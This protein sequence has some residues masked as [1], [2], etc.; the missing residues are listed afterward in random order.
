M[1]VLGAIQGLYL[2][3][4]RTGQPGVDMLGGPLPGYHVTLHPQDS[5]E[6]TAPGT[7]L[8][9]W[10]VGAQRKPRER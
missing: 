5:R 6:E 2:T 9:S 1:R 8:Q 3:L 10:S 7:T 4:A